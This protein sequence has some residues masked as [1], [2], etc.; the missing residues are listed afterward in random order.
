MSK[1]GEQVLETAL[2]LPPDERAELA[3]RL[4][5]SLDMKRQLQIDALWA[6]EAEDRI[7]AFER[8]QI[9]TVSLEEAFQTNQGSR[10]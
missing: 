3:E 6:A 4:L 8:G 1:L 5:S 2:T 9:N 10:P 7:D